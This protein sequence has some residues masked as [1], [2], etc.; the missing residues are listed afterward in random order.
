M[1]MD[2]TTHRLNYIDP[3]NKKLNGPIPTSMFNL[4]GCKFYS[5][6]K[7]F[8]LKI[9]YIKKQEGTTIGEMGIKLRIPETNQNTDL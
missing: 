4:V 6:F 3:C 7:F 8:F 5:K 1:T 2:T 9:V